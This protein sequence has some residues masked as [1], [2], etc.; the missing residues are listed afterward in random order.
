MDEAGIADGSL[1]LVKQQDVAGSGE[2]VVALVDDEVTIKELRLSASAA[3]LMPRSSNTSHKAI[4]AT[5][6]MRVQ[7]VVVASISDAAD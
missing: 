1:V 5:R 4:L 6:E 2:I 7:G 3:A